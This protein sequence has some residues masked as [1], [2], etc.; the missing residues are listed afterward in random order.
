MWVPGAFELPMAAKW[1]CQAGQFDVV[2]CLGAVIRGDT[3]HFD[4]IARAVADGLMNVAL[5]EGRPVVFGVLTTET[6]EQAE[7]RAAS[8]GLNRGADAARTAIEMA[9]LSKRFAQRT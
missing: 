3:A 9:A 4:F 7:E 5:A 2:I 1:L 6:V 8:E